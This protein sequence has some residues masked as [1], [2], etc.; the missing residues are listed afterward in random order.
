MLARKIMNYYLDDGQ[1]KLVPD[2]LDAKAKEI[3]ER[4]V[5]LNNRGFADFREGVSSSQLRRFFMEFRGLEKRVQ[6]AKDFEAVLPLIRMVKSKAAYALNSGTGAKIPQSFQK[7][8]VD[9]I[10]A[11]HNRRDFEAFMLYFEAVV[12]FCYGVPGF[13]KKG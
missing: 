10:D 13:A 3:Q 4:I 6:H 12:G 2:L 11:I 8:L 1:T 7:F 9:N 5:P